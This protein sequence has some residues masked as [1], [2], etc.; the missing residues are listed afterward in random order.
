[1]R[2]DYCFYLFLRAEKPTY[3]TQFS[4]L[5]EYNVSFF[6]FFLSEIILYPRGGSKQIYDG[7]NISFPL[8]TTE[9]VIVREVFISPI[10]SRLLM[11]SY[12]RV[13]FIRA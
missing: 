4:V 11:I 2:C 8:G 6:F 3:V 13:V 10:E 7:V 5:P 9:T 1:M 12:A